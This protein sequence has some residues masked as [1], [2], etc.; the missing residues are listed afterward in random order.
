M[1]AMSSITVC[2][3]HGCDRKGGVVNLPVNFEE[4]A[5]DDTRLNSIFAIAHI[6]TQKHH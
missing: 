3:L 4:D 1:S 6:V 5:I 2:C